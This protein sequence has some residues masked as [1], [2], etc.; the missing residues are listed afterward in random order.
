MKTVSKANNVYDFIGCIKTVSVNGEKVKLVYDRMNFNRENPVFCCEYDLVIDGKNVG[1]VAVV[2]DSD[3]RLNGVSFPTDK[4]MLEYA[5]TAP[6]IVEEN[7]PAE[8]A[9]PVVVVEID[10]VRKGIKELNRINAKAGIGVE[11][12]ETNDVIKYEEC[13]EIGNPVKVVFVYDKNAKQY[14]K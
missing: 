2:N 4:A 13:N 12:T 11:I 9:E 10:D 14:R 1:R 3:Y 8:S 7:E 6:A 5:M